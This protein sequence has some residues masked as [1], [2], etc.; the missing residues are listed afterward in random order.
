MV[1]PNL[2]LAANIMR[3]DVHHGEGRP[4]EALDAYDDALGLDMEDRHALHVLRR[5]AEI[6]AGMGDA[7]EALATCEA[8]LTISPDDAYVLGLRERLAGPASRG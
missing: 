6:L 3:G 5:R 2:L 7:G 4:A 8:A 1:P